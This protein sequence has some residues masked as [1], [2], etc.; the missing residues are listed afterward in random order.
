MTW[1][2]RAGFTLIELLVVIAI[3]GVLIALLLPA[4]Q[5]AREAARRIQCTNNLKQLGLAVMNYE[6]ANGCF[7]LHSMNPPARTDTSLPMSWIPPLL[8]FTEQSSMYN[9]INFNRDMM[10]T[11][12]GL[13]NTTASTSNLSILTCPSDSNWQ[14]LRAVGGTLP[15]MFYGMTS[16]MGNFG[17]PGVIALTSGTIVPGNPNALC[18]SPTSCLY[19]NGQWGPVSIASI[20][21]GTSNTALISERLVG[22]NNSNFN[23]GSALARR[24][25]FRATGG[26]TAAGTGQTGAMDF[27]GKCNAIPGTQGTRFGGGSGQMWIATYPMWLVINAYNHFGTPNQMNCT[28]PQEPS[29]I[30]GNANG[31]A[32]YYVAPLGSAPP[33]SNHPGGVNVAFSDG[34]VKFIKDTTNPQAWWALGSRNGSEVVSSDSY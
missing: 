12:N 30:D 3:I 22:V 4:V 34:S 6:S 17:G 20:T 1:R 11:G 31:T 26:G 7:P 10:G 25:T 32:G 33:S 8:Q 23:R 29:G 15:N 27:F 19:P 21:D 13:V 14:P 24:G 16:Y 2:K 9:A 28:N 18:A 5:Q